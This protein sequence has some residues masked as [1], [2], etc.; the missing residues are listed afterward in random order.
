MILKPLI[1]FYLHPGDCS[2]GSTGVQVPVKC[3]A[4]W[5]NICL[6]KF[7]ISPDVRNDLKMNNFLPKLKSEPHVSLIAGTVHDNS[8]SEYSLK[9]SLSSGYE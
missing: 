9:H 1:L 5:L 8:V 3:R 7:N 2:I 6:Q 4:C